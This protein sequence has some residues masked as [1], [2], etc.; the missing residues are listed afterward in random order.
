MS[1]KNNINQPVLNQNTVFALS[2]YELQ[3][4]SDSTTLEIGA[5][6]FFLACNDPVK[7]FLIH[8]PWQAQKLNKIK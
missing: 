4:F 5:K 3:C 1:C 2:L 8:C 7:D 6:I